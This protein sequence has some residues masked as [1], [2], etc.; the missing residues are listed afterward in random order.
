MSTLRENSAGHTRF[1]EPAYEVHLANAEPQTG[2]DTVG[3]G[4]RDAI[5]YARLLLEIDQQQKDRPAPTRGAL[6]LDGQKIAKGL[7]VVGVSDV[8]LGRHG[9]RA[10]N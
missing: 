5:A 6:P 7:L 9:T 4:K 10:P 3:D 2:E 8:A 1:A